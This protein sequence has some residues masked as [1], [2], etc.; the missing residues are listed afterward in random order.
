[1]DIQQTDNAIIDKSLSAYK[2]N[3]TYLSFYCPN[4]IYG[5]EINAC[6]AHSVYV[7]KVSNQ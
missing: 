6:I 3:D 2:I 4:S 1:M 5:H 7:L